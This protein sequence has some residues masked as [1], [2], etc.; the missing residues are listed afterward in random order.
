MFC[1]RTVFAVVLVSL[2]QPLAAGQGEPA[3][4]APTRI[5]PLP[6]RLAFTEQS[7]LSDPVAVRRQGGSDLHRLI[8]AGSELETYTISDEVFDVVV[9]D[10]YAQS[11][12][13]G[14][15]VWMGTGKFPEAWLE[16]LRQRVLILIAPGNMRA[17][18]AQHQLPLDGVHN[19]G[20]L[21]RTDQR[22]VY[23]AGTGYGDGLA[24]SLVRA[25]PGVFRACVSAR[26][27]GQDVPKA[28]EFRLALQVA[29]SPIEDQAGGASATAP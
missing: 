22:R 6:A 9:P 21:Y 11:A 10:G 20:R 28:A 26:G 2:G 25:Y 29:D 5:I 18:L 7:P 14:V 12:P 16:V 4:P 13:A 27:Q 17:S 19:V 23:T 1:C 3:P 15:L 8:A 24:A